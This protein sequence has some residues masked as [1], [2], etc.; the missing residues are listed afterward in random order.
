MAEDF[1]LNEERKRRSFER[2][3]FMFQE[4]LYAQSAVPKTNR[5][6]RNLHS[7]FIILKRILVKTRKFEIEA[8]TSIIENGEYGS[9]NILAIE[10]T[11]LQLPINLQQIVSS[12]LQVRQRGLRHYMS[13]GTPQ[14]MLSDIHLGYSLGVSAVESVNYHF[15]SL[16]GDFYKKFDE[17][18]SPVVSISAEPS[19]ALSVPKGTGII[20]YETGESPLIDRKESIQNCLCLCYVSLPRWF[21]TNIRYSSTLA[22]EQYHKLQC[23]LEFCQDYMLS[24]PL[25]P[26]TDEFDDEQVLLDIPEEVVSD[27]ED[28]FGEAVTHLTFLK[29]EIEVSYTKHILGLGRKLDTEETDY[30]KRALRLQANE[31]IADMF[32]IAL[33]GP[34]YTYSFFS[35][36]LMFEDESYYAPSN[37]HPHFTQRIKLQTD[38]LES[39]GFEVDARAVRKELKDVVFR[40]LRNEKSNFNELGL[41]D[42]VENNASSFKKIAELIRVTADSQIYVGEKLSVEKVSEKIIEIVDGGDIYNLGNY[43]QGQIL[44]AMWYKVTNNK[45]RNKRE[46]YLRWRKV[47][48]YRALE[49]DDIEKKG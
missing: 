25:S 4:L 18:N 23:L 6:F 38:Y 13:S 15:H 32:G 24:H 47:L 36:I 7:L 12:L 9:I 10:E 41:D 29:R 19:Y 44:N 27:T 30:L 35:N 42:W 34:A 5:Y 43:S 20:G 39:W 3:E 45:Y 33:A 46:L 40:W 16:L 17:I 1:K 22:H 49:K 11:Y 14:Y 28:Q 8:E 2:F 37:Q 31:L 21:L 48:V 26:K